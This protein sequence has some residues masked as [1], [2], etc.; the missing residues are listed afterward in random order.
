MCTALSFHT[1]DHYFGRTLDLD[2][3]YGEEVCVMPRKFPLHFRQMG[4]INEHYAIIGMA[5]V[6]QGIPLFY[7]AANE[8]GLAIAG[9]NFPGNAY[10]ASLAEGKTIFPPLN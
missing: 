4:E 9:L 5:T 6:V 8:Y 2:R 3:S 1:K 7:D 10:Y